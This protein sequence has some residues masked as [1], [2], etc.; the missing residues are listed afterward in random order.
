MYIGLT[1]ITILLLGVLTRFAEIK[2]EHL[3]I[4]GYHNKWINQGTIIAF[5]LGFASG[6]VSS[7]AHLP[8]LIGLLLYTLGYFGSYLIFRDI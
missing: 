1:V 8:I 5:F 6:I 4:F 7:S 3:S 2:F